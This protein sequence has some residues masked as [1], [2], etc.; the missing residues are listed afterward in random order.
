[1][2]GS[3]HASPISAW[4]ESWL[5]WLAAERQYAAHTLDAYARDATLTYPSLTSRTAHQ[6]HLTGMISDLF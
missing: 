2:K 4:R 6:I 3:S 1:M 5:N